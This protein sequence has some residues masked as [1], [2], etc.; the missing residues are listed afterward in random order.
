MEK[1]DL[2][3]SGRFEV[4]QMENYD[5]LPMNQDAILVLRVELI[6]ILARF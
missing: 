2:T 1:G 4:A 6:N 5:D 3:R